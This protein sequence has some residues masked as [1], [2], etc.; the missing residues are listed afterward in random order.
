MKWY[1]EK[2]TICLDLDKISYWEY[3]K[4]P[5]AL[6]VYIGGQNPIMFYN[7]DAEEIYN[8]LISSKEVI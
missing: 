6:E 7:K 8:M 1:N 3:Y 5:T 4:G 2:K